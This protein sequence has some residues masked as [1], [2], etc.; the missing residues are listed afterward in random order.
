MKGKVDLRKKRQ[1]RVRK[2]LRNVNQRSRL[3]LVKSC[4]YLHAQVIDDE[5]RETLVAASTS[6]KAFKE[7]Q[8]SG[9]NR[10]SAKRLGVVIAQLAREK[11]I[12]KVVLDRGKSKYH[13]VVAAFADA[14]RE[15][16]LSF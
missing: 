14:A 7:G 15:H 11:S 1:L 2:K 5:K 13:G 16:G 4:R 6:S 12:E 9:K 3:C 8:G 10:E